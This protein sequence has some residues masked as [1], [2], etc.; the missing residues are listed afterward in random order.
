MIRRGEADDF[1]SRTGGERNAH[2]QHARADGDFAGAVLDERALRNW[3]AT[4][5]PGKDLGQRIPEVSERRKDGS[6][7][8]SMSDHIPSRAWRLGMSDW[9]V[10]TGIALYS[11]F[12]RSTS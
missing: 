2:R 5:N 6:W 3:S 12:C 4:R 7:C 11:H 1:Q 10:G 8:D 9:N